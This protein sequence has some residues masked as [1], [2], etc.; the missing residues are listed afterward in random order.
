MKNYK[1]GSYW[2]LGLFGLIGFYKLPTMVDYFQG[3]ESIWQL[4]NILWFSW[5]SYFI[6]KKVNSR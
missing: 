4:L 3:Q 2:F 5:F 6:P 1:F